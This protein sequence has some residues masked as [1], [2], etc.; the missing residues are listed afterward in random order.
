MKKLIMF[1]FTAIFLLHGHAFG[2]FDFIDNGDGTVTDTRTNLVWLKSANLFGFVSYEAAG[3]MCAYMKDGRF[4]LTDGSS[5]G[6]WH[7]PSKAQIEGLGTDPPATWEMG[8]PPVIWAMPGAPFTDIQTGLYWS[9]PYLY[10]SAYVLNMSNGDL[11]Q[12]HRGSTCGV[13][14]VRNPITTTTTIVPTTTTTVPPDAQCTDQYQSGE[15]YIVY[16]GSNLNCPF[17]DW[18]LVNYFQHIVPFPESIQNIEY[19]ATVNLNGATGCI[20]LRVVIENNYGTAQYFNNVTDGQN[21]TINIPRSYFENTNFDGCS[22]T[23]F[24]HT[25]DI[26]WQFQPCGG[27]WLGGSNIISSPKPGC[28]LNLNTCCP[29]STCCTPTAITLLSFTAKPGKGLVTLNWATETEIDNAGFNIYRATA[30]DGEYIKINHSVIP[31]EGD[32]T[33]GASYEF[34]DSGLRNGKTYYYKLEDVDFNGTSAFHDPVKAVPR[35]WLGL[36]R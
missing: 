5:E 18:G 3:N 2:S 1:C 12:A 9:E 20:D 28:N 22:S 36:K 16:T 23:W 35:W 31:A 6:Q 15:P 11:G 24:V 10:D 7:L 32:L 29:D 30:E 26:G 33:K 25:A 13:W 4:G 27:G 14:P 8:S 17:V 21:I 19:Y 34:I